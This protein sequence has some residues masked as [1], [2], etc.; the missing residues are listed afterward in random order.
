M[1]PTNY[2]RKSPAYSSPYIFRAKAFGDDFAEAL[3]DA[4]M[5]VTDIYAA[6]KNPGDINSQMLAEKFLSKV[7][8]QNTS[9]I[10]RNS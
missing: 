1:I 3:L 6:R 10:L 9:A 8:I 5:V 4:D 2:Q 7:T